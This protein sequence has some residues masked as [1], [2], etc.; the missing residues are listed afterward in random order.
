MIYVICDVK[1]IIY[2]CDKECNECNDVNQYSAFMKF[3]IMSS[4]SNDKKRYMLQ[5]LI[6]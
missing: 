3:N 4:D 2:M 6:N 1:K 5:M